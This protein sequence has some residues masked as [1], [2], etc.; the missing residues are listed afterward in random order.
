MIKTEEQSGTIGDAE[1][2]LQKGGELSFEEAF[3]TTGKYYY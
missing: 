2:S 3:E 1:K